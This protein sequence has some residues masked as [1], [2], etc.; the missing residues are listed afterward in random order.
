MKKILSWLFGQTSFIII[1]LALQLYIILSSAFRIASDEALAAL[2]AINGV[3]SV[4][5]IIHIINSRESPE[6]KMTWIAMIAISPVL[7]NFF[8]LFIKFQ[9]VPMMLNKTLRRIREE[10]SPYII[11]DPSIIPEVASK[12]KQK[13]NFISYMNKYAEFPAFRN[14]DA[15]YLPIGEEA[16]KVML[17][18]M[19]KAEKY[20]FLEFYIIGKGEMWSSIVDIL[21]RKAAQGVDVRVMYDGIGCLP[22]L[23]YRYPR[24]LEEMGIKCKVFN[25]FRPFLSTI[26]NNRSHRKI[27]VV[28]GKT[29]FTGGINLSDEYVNITSPY[30]HW[31]D[32]G[33]LVRGEAAFSFAV[34]FLE[35]WQI[36]NQCRE[37]YE[38]FRPHDL[39][40]YD[41]PGYVIPYSDSPFD[42]ELVGETVYMDILG[43]ARDYVHI[44]TPYM[45]I[46][47]ELITALGNAAK[48]GVDVKVIVPHVADHWY[49]HAVAKAYYA[50]L[51]S[52]GVELYEYM[53]GFIHSKSFVSD[54]NTAV[55]GT[56][57]L[58]FRSLHHHF[59]CAVWMYDHKTVHDVERD[60]QETLAQCRPITLEST[61][62]RGLAKKAL[63]S[64]L[65]IF[66]PLM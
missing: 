24:E 9:S 11:Q 34:M 47:N 53:P 50:D 25:P 6:S 33:M 55:V 21:R 20:I 49:A 46:D 61:R 16:W 51:I 65:R 41:E 45:I 52:R 5:L 2:N 8:Y 40:L 28:D 31:K 66:A 44:T 32:T 42:N 43:K 3:L 30:G 13:A 19:E 62:V 27:L 23:P 15:R 35:L 58:D 60:F 4:L 17:E 26:Q 12:D 56:I 14:T 10:S 18:E 22:R 57:N 1:M 63:Y 59:E 38:D 48:S 37:N 36:S 54:D 64:V 7:G 29:A 39:P